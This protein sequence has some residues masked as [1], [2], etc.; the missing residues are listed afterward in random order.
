MCSAKPYITVELSSSTCH[1][2]LRAFSTIAFQTI[3]TF[4]FITSNGPTV[5]PLSVTIAADAYC[6]LNKMKAVIA[7]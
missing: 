4:Y 2:K 7:G 3:S 5:W 1:G 6:T